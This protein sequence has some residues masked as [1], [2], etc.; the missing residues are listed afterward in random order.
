MQTKI[1][2]LAIA[3]SLGGVF[4]GGVA[5]GKEMKATKYMA[6]EELKWVDLG[7]GPKLGVLTGDK[8]KGPHLSLMRL[9]GGFESPW[10]S[11]S[12]D[13]EAVQ[14]AGTSRHW[15]KGEDPA[16]AKRLGPG[17]YWSIPGGA[18]HVSVC[19]KGADCTLLLIQKTKFDFV[20]AK[21]AKPA[22]PPAK[23][24]GAT[25]ATPATPAK[26]SAPPAKKTP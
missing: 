26:P 23:G 9:P 4:V 6:R 8:D 7:G 19:E 2:A 18:D 13:Y 12:G 14:I 25:P 24:A 21:D 16:K 11:H 20:P 3:L 17:S 5:V 10:H 15:V 22:T 1:K